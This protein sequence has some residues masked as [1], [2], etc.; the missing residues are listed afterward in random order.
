MAVIKTG[1]TWPEIISKPWSTAEC[2]FESRLYEFYVKRNSQFKHKIV[3]WLGSAWL[4]R[5]WRFPQLETSIR[6][7]FPISFIQHK[8][9]Y[10]TNCLK[11]SYERRK[12]D[13]DV[14]NNLRTCSFNS[15]F[16]FLN[17]KKLKKNVPSLATTELG[18]AAYFSTIGS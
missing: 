7:F 12:N 16:S 17:H 1:C 4:A 10:V 6:S 18:L 2:L 8:T 14:Y 13:E 9:I 3:C 15:K 5:K 11:I